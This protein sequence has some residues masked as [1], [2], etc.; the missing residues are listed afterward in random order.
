MFKGIFESKNVK[1]MVV[2]IFKF[3]FEKIL[4]YSKKSHFITKHECQLMKETASEGGS[5][6]TSNMLLF[7]RNPV[8]NLHAYFEG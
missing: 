5:S 1:L 6:Q 2:N 4:L 8:S 3:S 7:F